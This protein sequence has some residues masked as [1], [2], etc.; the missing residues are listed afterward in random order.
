MNFLRKIMLQVFD[1]HLKKDITQQI[2]T[3]LF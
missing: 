3:Y 1:M 2:Q